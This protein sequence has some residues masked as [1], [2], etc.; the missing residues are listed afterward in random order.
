M[1]DRAERGYGATVTL[2]AILLPYASH[3]GN[4]ETSVR[5]QATEP[6]LEDGRIYR[7]RWWV[8]KRDSG[9]ELDL[10]EFIEQIRRS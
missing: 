3:Y 1:R 4:R 8:V 5:R 2:L 9:G 6:H 10:L 7:T